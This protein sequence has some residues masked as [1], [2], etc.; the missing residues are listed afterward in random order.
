[1][2]LLRGSPYLSQVQARAQADHG[3]S[4]AEAAASSHACSCRPSAAVGIEEA[5][6]G[7]LSSWNAASRT[8]RRYAA[9]LCKLISCKLCRHHHSPL[10]VQKL[11]QGLKASK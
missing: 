11:I 2:L 1:M 10:V 3:G 9:L 7:E 6:S 4:Q 8:M 5:C